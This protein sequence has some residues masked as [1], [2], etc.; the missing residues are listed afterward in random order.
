MCP[1]G[2]THCH[3]KTMPRCCYCCPHKSLFRTQCHR[4]QC[5]RGNTCHQST[6]NR[7]CTMFC[8]TC[9]PKCRILYT[10]V[11]QC[12]TMLN[13][14]ALRQWYIPP[15]MYQMYEQATNTYTLSHYQ[16]LL[17]AKKNTLFDIASMSYHRNSN[18]S[19]R[20]HINLYY[21][22]LIQSCNLRMWNGYKCL[23]YHHMI[24]LRLYVP[25]RHLCCA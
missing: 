6:N 14:N 7:S 3:N 21:R 8:Y 11:Y 19:Y 10:S 25:H 13:K 4:Q 5:I 9:F 2:R 15:C 20:L 23:L 1:R 18:L 17:P 22:V 24:R 12:M 16:G